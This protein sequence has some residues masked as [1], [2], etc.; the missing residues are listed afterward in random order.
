M[1]LPTSVVIAGCDSMEIVQ[2]ALKVAREFKPL[3]DAERSSLLAKTEVPAKNGQYE[4]YKTSH[5]FDGT[6]HNPQWLG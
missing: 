1:S 4:L 2:Q 3:S 6:Y 5:T